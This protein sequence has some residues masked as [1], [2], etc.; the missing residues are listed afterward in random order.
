[1]SRAICLFLI[2]AASNA[3]AG[4]Y[5]LKIEKVVTRSV[6]KGDRTVSKQTDAVRSIETL[7]RLGEPF[8]VRS[9]FATESLT[10]TGE[11]CGTKKGT[12]RLQICIADARESKHTIERENGER[13]PLL[14]RRGI[15][16][17]IAIKPNVPLGLGGSISHVTNGD[18]DRIEKSKTVRFVATL[19]RF[20][21]RA[22]QK[23]GHEVEKGGCR[24]QP[25]NQ[26]QQDDRLHAKDEEPGARRANKPVATRSSFCPLDLIGLTVRLVRRF[27]VSVGG[28]GRRLF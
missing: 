1:M 23:A 27:P 28:G 14:L 3:R 6:T 9:V 8:R 25:L 18:A 12:L 10:A 24:S 7:C 11:L 19:T 17:Q 15:S 20:H 21:P 5:L 22:G 13:K 26:S 2:L 16:T 4:D